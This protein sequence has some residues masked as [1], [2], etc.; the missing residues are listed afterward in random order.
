[1]ADIDGIKQEKSQKNFFTDVPQ[2]S[3]GFFLK[4]SHQYD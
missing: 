1:M 4:G 3:P 2:T